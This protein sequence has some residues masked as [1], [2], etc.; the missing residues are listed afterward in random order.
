MNKINN[1]INNNYFEIFDRINHLDYSSDVANNNAN[2]NY[3]NT[4]IFYKKMT[5]ET[6]PFMLNLK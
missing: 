6:I 3:Y 1:Q 4:E 2:E 5:N